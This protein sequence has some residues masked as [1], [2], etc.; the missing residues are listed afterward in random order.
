MALAEHEH[1]LDPRLVHGDGHE[2]DL[3]PLSDPKTPNIQN[4]L[5]MNHDNNENLKY[6]YENAICF[7]NII[8]TMA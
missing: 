5:L 4:I 2:D 1:Y 7:L 8:E 3:E 6:S